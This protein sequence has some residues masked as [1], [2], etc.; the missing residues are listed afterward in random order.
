[1]HT[2]W[3]R[4]AH[5]VCVEK[6]GILPPPGIEGHSFI[7]WPVT[8]LI[9]FPQ[10]TFMIYC[11]LLKLL[12]HVFCHKLISEMDKVLAVERRCMFRS[13]VCKRNA[14]EASG[15]YVTLKKDKRSLGPLYK[16]FHPVRDLCNTLPSHIRNLVLI[17][18]RV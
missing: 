3:I 1:M 12:T 8:V 4:A 10:F 15:R 16:W 6:N 14:M 7:P 18:E 9:K 11:P 13:A 2:Q 17:G 5:L